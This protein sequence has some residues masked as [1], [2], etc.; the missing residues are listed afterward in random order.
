MCVAVEDGPSDRLLRGG[1][2]DKE[3]LSDYI[4]SA[5]SIW[6]EGTTMKSETPDFLPLRIGC[7]TTPKTC[8]FAS[9][10]ALG[11]SL[12]LASLLLATGTPAQA[13]GAIV[14]TLAGS[15]AEGSVDGPGDKASFLRPQSV[16]VDA[17]GN[18][19]V[20]DRYS[21][22]IRKITQA[23][24]VSTLAGSGTVGSADGVGAKASFNEPVGVAVDASGNVYV[25]DYANSKIRMV[26]SA[27]VVSTFAGSGAQGSA[28]GPP[29]TA[30]FN[31]PTGVA[32]DTSGN[33]YVADFGN[34][35]IRKVTPAGIV[36]TLAG[37]AVQGSIDGP[38][39][40]ASFQRPQGVAVDASGN[41]YVADRHNNKIRKITPKGVVS[42]LAG[43]GAPGIAGGPGAKASFNEPVGVAVDASGN[44]YVADYA[45]SRIRM[46]TSAGIV[47]TVAG[48]GAQGSADG[49]EYSASFF[50]PT[51]VAV[52]AAGNL[53]VADYGNQ[54]VRKITKVVGKRPF[55]SKP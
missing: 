26:T 17:S 4:G 2:D 7:R 52:D 49:R 40:K 31:L 51:G 3:K 13:A 23:G 32:V 6:T 42:T 35:K 28:D 21:N 50:V 20:A 27:G 37:S 41:V 9:S 33:L 30:S 10:L 44:V 46:V 8:P 34:H 43:S 24:V 14:S 29:A 53:Y 16:A 11:A 18:V 12:G 54:K 19:Y 55:G 22:K 1:G 25:A 5:R 47:S 45:S 38:G 15:G 36:S 48:S 39:E